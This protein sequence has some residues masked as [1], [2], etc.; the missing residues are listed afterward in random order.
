M[1]CDGGVGNQRGRGGGVVGKEGKVHESQNAGENSSK[2]DSVV[3]HTQCSY[4]MYWKCERENANRKLIQGV[5]LHL[6][7]L[8][9]RVRVAHSRVAPLLQPEMHLWL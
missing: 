3:V 5:V 2:D 4:A 7:V 8:L 6:N 1:G 9:L